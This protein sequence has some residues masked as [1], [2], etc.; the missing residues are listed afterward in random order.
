MGIKSGPCMSNDVSNGL[1]P[2]RLTG[3]RVVG[4]QSAQCM[5]TP[6]QAW[7]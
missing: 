2:Q 3:S 5:V 6:L 4:A 1:L 7:R